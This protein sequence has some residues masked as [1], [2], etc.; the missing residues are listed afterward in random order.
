MQLY[1]WEIKTVD[2]NFCD[3]NAEYNLLEVILTMFMNLCDLKYII[4]NP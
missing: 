3:F 1:Y 4:Q 2:Y